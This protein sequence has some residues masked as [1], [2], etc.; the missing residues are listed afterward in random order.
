MIDF[1][2]NYDEASFFVS[3]DTGSGDGTGVSSPSTGSGN[4]LNGWAGRE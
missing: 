3:V 2:H 1:D 4:R